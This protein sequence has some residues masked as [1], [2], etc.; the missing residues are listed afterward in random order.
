MK[1][2]KLLLNGQNR[3]LEKN[4]NN[5]LHFVYELWL[6]RDIMVLNFIPEQLGE[7]IREGAD[8]VI[9]SYL[10]DMLFCQK[11][12]FVSPG[13]AGWHLG[14]GSL[15]SICPSH[16]LCVACINRLHMSLEHSYCYWLYVFYSC[17]SVEFKQSL[18]ATELKKQQ[19]KTAAFV[20]L[21]TKKTKRKLATET[22]L[23]ISAQD[24]T[25]SASLSSSGIFSIPF[26]NKRVKSNSLTICV[27]L[28]KYLENSILI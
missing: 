17:F 15:P 13:E 22:P 4:L 21:W 25:G 8:H 12:L 23:I 6:H 7:I 1:K 18:C 26:K 11:V 16:F 3:Q 9:H 2:E 10:E 20:E 5:L 14:I 28:Q 19:K 24:F 27:C